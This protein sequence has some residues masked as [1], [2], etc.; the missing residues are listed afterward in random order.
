MRVH[1]GQRRHQ[2]LACAIDADG[3][4]RHFSLSVR[5]DA[6]DA[7]L[8]YDD[9]L[10]AKDGVAIHGNHVDADECRRWTRLSRGKGRDSSE[11]RSTRTGDRSED[12]HAHNSFARSYQL[13]S[14]QAMGW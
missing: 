10:I 5:S 6:H 9:G 2:E 11:E 7:A 3:A 4:G 13:G 14:E 12:L 1:L 8:A